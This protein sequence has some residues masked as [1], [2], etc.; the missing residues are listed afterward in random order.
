MTVLI[1][2][3]AFRAAASINL[4]SI[5]KMLVSAV[6]ALF[7]AF[8]HTLLHILFIYLILNPKQQVCSRLHNS[9][10]NAKILGP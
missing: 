5:N 2:W 8:G 4:Y 6:F 10:Q 3:I 7:L 1:S 9:V